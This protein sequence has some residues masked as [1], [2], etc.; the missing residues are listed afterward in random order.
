[1]AT[2]PMEPPSCDKGLMWRL[3]AQEAHVSCHHCGL[4]AVCSQGPPS[5]VRDAQG[6]WTCSVCLDLRTPMLGLEHSPET[7]MAVL[8]NYAANQQVLE[9]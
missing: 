5:N 6:R 9:H 4:L 3:M 7:G 8:E 2:T 1:M